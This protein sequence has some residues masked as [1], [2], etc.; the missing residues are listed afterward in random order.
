[1]LVHV[2]VEEGY[3]L[4]PSVED[5]LPPEQI[6]AAVRSALRPLSDVRAVA[7]VVVHYLDQ[8]TLAEVQIQVDP[9]LRV[10]DA[11]AIARRAK[12]AIEQ[13]PE[14]DE[15]H[16]DLEINEAH[17]WHRL[18]GRNRKPAPPSP[19]SVTPIQ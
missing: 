2:D 19:P 8:N 6:E 14:V 11:Q 9:S 5:T 15:A 18:R 7:H 10:S 12:L 4:H 17:H 13:L 16:V 3:A 1:M